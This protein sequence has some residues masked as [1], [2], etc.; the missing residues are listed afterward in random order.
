MFKTWIPAQHATRVQS[1]STFFF[2]RTPEFA[3]LK[4]NYKLSWPL[5][6]AGATRIS[7]APAYPSPVLFLP[8]NC[9]LCSLYIIC[10]TPRPICG[11]KY[12]WNNTKLCNWD[13]S[14]LREMYWKKMIGQRWV[15]VEVSTS[16]S[17][18]VRTICNTSV[19]ISSE[20]WNNKYIY[21][22]HKMTSEPRYES[23]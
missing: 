1:S 17:P 23:N 4:K 20:L 13:G 22:L 5:L 8:F 18:H 21:C 6:S 10:Y 16:A 12:T 19:M 15:N 7:L 11:D 14:L 3:I 9:F 2:C